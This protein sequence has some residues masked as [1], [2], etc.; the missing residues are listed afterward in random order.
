MRQ[1][2]F[3]QI[4]SNWDVSDALRRI[5]K[6]FLHEKIVYYSNGYTEYESRLFNFIDNN[7][8]AFWKNN[9]HMLCLRDFLDSLHF[10]ELYEKATKEKNDESI[11]DYIEIVENCLY[12]FD[13]KHY[14]PGII[15]VT[16]SDTLHLLRDNLADVLDWLNM[17]V[18]YFAE[19]EQAIIIERDP[20][21]TAAV[22]IS[23]NE[24]AYEILFYNHHTLKG[25]V[26]EKVKI[27]N[28][29]ANEFEA[30]RALLKQVN[31][32]L[33]DDIAS[34]LNN[35]NIRHNNVDQSSTSYHSTVADMPSDEL[36]SWYDE[37]YQMLLLAKLEIDNIERKKKVAELKKKF[38]NEGKNNG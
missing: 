7:C 8:F 37:L 17:E 9:G 30:Q 20:A 18:A 36:E 28:Y 14:A 25:N 10:D 1:N 32:G 27:L 34:L 11:I 24:T 2:I 33:A 13:S 4:K 19:K 26:R 35:L 38:G 22:E 6:L 12:I 31:S 21:V 29:L 15:D 23:S 3:E 16:G 5:H